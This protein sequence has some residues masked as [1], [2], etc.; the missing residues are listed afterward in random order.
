MRYF[1]EDGGDEGL[2]MSEQLRQG[3]IEEEVGRH[4][5]ASE[6]LSA[7]PRASLL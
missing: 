7:S 6:W 2:H 5:H 1:L 4:T 3:S